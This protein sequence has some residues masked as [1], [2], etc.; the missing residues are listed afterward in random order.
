M[1]A[2][3]MSRPFSEPVMLTRRSVKLLEPT[4]V[5]LAPSP[6]SDESSISRPLLLFCT[7]QAL[8]PWIRELRIVTFGAFTTTH[9][10]STPSITVPACVMV[11]GPDGLRTV[12]AGTPVFEASGNPLGGPAV[13]GAGVAPACGACGLP[14]PTLDAYM[15]AA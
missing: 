7:S 2:P 12:P 3:P 4:A 1:L 15:L 13:A 14:T 5:L 10:A 9:G 11:R 6:S 8:P